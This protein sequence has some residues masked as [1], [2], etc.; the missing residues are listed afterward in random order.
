MV[1]GG[2]DGRGNLRCDVKG[3]RQTLIQ[4]VQRP[5]TWFEAHAQLN[6]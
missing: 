5:A 6:F 4:V 3:G 1:L 2:E